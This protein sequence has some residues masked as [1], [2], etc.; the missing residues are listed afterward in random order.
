MS[1]NTVIDNNRMIEL[2]VTE[3]DVKYGI[4]DFSKNTIIEAK[5]DAIYFPDNY[6]GLKDVYTVKQ[7]DVLWK[8][9]LEYGMLPQELYD[10]NRDVIGDNPNL[11]LPGQELKTNLTYLLNP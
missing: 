7:G 6:G 1:R 5:Y 3:K 8:I 4:M 9:A 2:K 11:I 10:L